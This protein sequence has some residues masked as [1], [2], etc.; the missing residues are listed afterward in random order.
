MSIVTCDDDFLPL[1]DICVSSYRLTVTY[2][3]I[4]RLFPVISGIFSSSLEYLK[5]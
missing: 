4:I 5:F 2:Y 1:T 3:I